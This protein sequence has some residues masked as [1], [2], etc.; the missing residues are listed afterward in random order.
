MEK[1]FIKSLLRIVLFHKNSLS[2]IRAANLTHRPVRSF[3]RLSYDLE[4]IWAYADR[5]QKDYLYKYVYGLHELIFPAFLS[6]DAA[7]IGLYFSL[8]DDFCLAEDLYHRYLIAYFAFRLLRQRHECPSQEPHCL[9]F[10]H[11]QCICFSIPS[12]CLA[13][14]RRLVLISAG[15]EDFDLLTL[16]L[17]AFY[18]VWITFMF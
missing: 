1:V 8:R 17:S 14:W 18:V 3:L 7:S 2:K 11:C 12:V 16:R 5:Y 15:L 13:S 6:W 9:V 10:H 4:S